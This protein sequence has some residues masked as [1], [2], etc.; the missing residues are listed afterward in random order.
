MN[1]FN[2]TSQP[3]TSVPYNTTTIR[4]AQYCLYGSMSGSSGH[5]LVYDNASVADETFSSF[6]ATRD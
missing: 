1:D 5:R 6:G 2:A 4:D 3:N